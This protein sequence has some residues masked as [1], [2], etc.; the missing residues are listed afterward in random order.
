M[1]VTP[2]VY[3]KKPGYP[4]GAVMKSQTICAALFLAVRD[5]IS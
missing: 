5:G 4:T 3:Y 2:V 1:K